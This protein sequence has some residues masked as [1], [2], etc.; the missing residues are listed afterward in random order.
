GQHALAPRDG[1]HRHDARAGGGLRPP[2][3]ARRPSVAPPR[4]L[5]P[6][7]G[8]LEGPERNVL[9]AA[10][11][12]ERPVSPVRSGTG[13]LQS[14]APRSGPGK[15]HPRQD[16]VSVRAPAKYPDRTNHRTRAT[17]RTRG[18]LPIVG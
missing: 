16:D 14:P 5:S 4:V 3:P 8:A 11:L 1:A 17:S 18:P 12:P 6:E 2:A 13:R 15:L 9:K 10:G 7:Q